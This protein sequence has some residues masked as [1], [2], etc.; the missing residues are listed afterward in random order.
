MKLS[1]FLIKENVE[2]NATQMERREVSLEQLRG[3]CHPVKLNKKYLNLF[4]DIQIEDKKPFNENEEIKDISEILNIN[5][6]I[7]E[8]IITDQRPRLEQYLDF[9]FIL[10]KSINLH[11]EK[12]FLKTEYQVGLKILENIVICIHK[13]KPVSLEQLY[14]YFIRNERNLKKGGVTYLT[15][16]YLDCLTDPIFSVLG[17][18]RKLSKDLEKKILKKPN[19]D[20]LN[21]MIDLRASIMDVDYI[22]RADKEVINRMLAL[23]SI[24]TKKFIPPELDDHIVHCTD[25]AKILFDIISDLMSIY[26][27]SESSILDKSLAR[28]TVITATFLLPSLIAGIFGMNNPGFPEINFY[29]VILI[30]LCFMALIFIYFKRKDMI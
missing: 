14:R 10:F 15:A 5:L 8:E 30:M 27:S 23:P 19:K 25:E 28:L 11:E 3:E 9:T 16:T 26:Y 6:P 24:F 13:N 20:L 17:N 12:D 18:W 21:I 4:L 2:K 7:L 1:Y 22:L 29:W